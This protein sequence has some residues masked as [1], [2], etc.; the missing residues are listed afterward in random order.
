MLTVHLAPL[1]LQTTTLN[2]LSLISLIDDRALATQY[3]SNQ[4]LELYLAN[5]IQWGKLMHFKEIS[6]GKNLTF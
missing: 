3:F 2:V 5:L 4:Q 1:H 6:F